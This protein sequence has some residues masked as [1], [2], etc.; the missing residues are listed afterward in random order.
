MKPPPFDYVAARSIDHAVELLN[1]EAEARV[2]A[3]G[4]SLLPLLNLRLASP[5]VLVDIG[6]IPELQAVTID[7][8]VLVVGAGA[9][10]A[11]VAADP[12]VVEVYLGR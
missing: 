4:Q 10:Q 1:G 12:R 3:G 5:E 6:R 9:A 11:D 2:L 7:E 8:D